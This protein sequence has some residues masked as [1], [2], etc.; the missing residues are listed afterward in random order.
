MDS[1][2]IPE[3]ATLKSPKLSLFVDWYWLLVARLPEGL[4]D[5]GRGSIRTGLVTICDLNHCIQLSNLSHKLCTLTH[6]KSTS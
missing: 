3:T 2:G 6:D 5:D 4:L 1:L